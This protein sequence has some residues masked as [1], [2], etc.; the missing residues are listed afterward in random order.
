MPVSDEDL[1]ETYAQYFREVQSTPLATA[2]TLSRLFPE[3]DERREGL[4]RLVQLREDL[5]LGLGDPYRTAVRDAMARLEAEG[6]AEAMRGAW[7]EAVRLVVEGMADPREWSPGE[8]EHAVSLRAW[9]APWFVM[10][11][12][13]SGAVMRWRVNNC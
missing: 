9:T 12:D 3:G 7:E 5:E 1:R 10:L 11:F 4:R 8:V 13:E 6:A 2:R